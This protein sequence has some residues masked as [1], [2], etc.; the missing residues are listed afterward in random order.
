MGPLRCQLSDCIGMMLHLSRGYIIR[1]ILPSGRTKTYIFIYLTRVKLC[2]CVI[3]LR[4]HRIYIY[5][6][7]HDIANRM[8]GLISCV[9]FQSRRLNPTCV[10]RVLS[11]HF[12]GGS[13]GV[14][15][16]L[17]NVCVIN[18]PRS[19]HLYSPNELRCRQG[20]TVFFVNSGCRN[21]FN[22]NAPHDDERQTYRSA[23]TH[24]YMSLPG[25]RS[26]FN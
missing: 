1:A 17:V 19:L 23:Y 4:L 18:T 24:T 5:T 9:W 6:Y 20:P 8:G 22:M 15:F 7:L 14:I 11:A 3:C 2:C 21:E 25:M 12:A 16:V 10:P 13:C 26:S